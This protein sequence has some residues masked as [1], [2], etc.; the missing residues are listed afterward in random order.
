MKLN[1]LIYVI[2]L[3]PPKLKIKMRLL[4]IHVL[5]LLGRKKKNRKR[6]GR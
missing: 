6:V 5:E 1:S 3:M 2:D 4:Y